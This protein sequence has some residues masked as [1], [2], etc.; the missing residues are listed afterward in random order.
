V[1]CRGNARE[2]MRKKEV[3][4]LLRVD[5]GFCEEWTIAFS[6]S[7]QWAMSCLQHVLQQAVRKRSVCAVVFN[8]T[9]K[10][11]RVVQLYRNAKLSPEQ[12]SLDHVVRYYQSLFTPSGR[13][14]EIPKA[15]YHNH[16]LINAP[17]TIKH[18]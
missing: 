9:I 7:G 13:D 4:W 17:M 6:R 3:L 10:R 14:C 12:R 11:G 8:W 18:S 15:I 5:N 16:L 2:D 1:T